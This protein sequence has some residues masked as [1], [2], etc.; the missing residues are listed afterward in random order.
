MISGT[1]PFGAEILKKIESA[2]H[3][4]MNERMKGFF[5]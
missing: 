2:R 5:L 3:I 1:L 4:N